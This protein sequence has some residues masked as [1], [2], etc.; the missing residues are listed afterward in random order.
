MFVINLQID[1]AFQ[2][3]LNYKLY[4]APPKYE[5]RVPL[6]KTFVGPKNTLTMEE[7][8]KLAAQTENMS[9]SAMKTYIQNKKD[10]LQDK[11]SNARYFVLVN[12]PSEG[13]KFVPCR[14]QI[15]GR[16]K[17]EEFDFHFS[18]IYCPQIRFK[19]LTNQDCS[20]NERGKGQKKNY[21]DFMKLNKEDFQK[22]SGVKVEDESYPDSMYQEY[23]RLHE[24]NPTFA[25]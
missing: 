2:R 14:K 13:P 20:K 17:R 21:R 7:W 6:L 11:I 19:D 12:I 16:V 23:C 24:C 22:M 4:I 1:S 5:D 3:R 8:D 18:K 25:N 10:E 9:T 15:K